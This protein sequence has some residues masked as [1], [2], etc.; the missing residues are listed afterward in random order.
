MTPR[1]TR[2]RFLGGRLTLEQPASGYRAGIDAVLLAA[3]VPAE[4]GERVL[5]LGVGTG[6]ASLCLGARVGGLALSGLEL[7]PAYA[8][9]ARRN[10]A[11]N[12]IPLE[13]VVGDVAEMPAVLRARTF[14]HVMMNPPYH[15]RSEGTPAADPGRETALG[16]AAPL[17]LWV[18]AAAR[19]LR[20]GGH[21]TAIQRAERLPGLLSALDGR[22]GSIAVLPVAPRSGR[23][24]R[25]VILRARKG[26]RGAFRLLAPLILHEGERHLRDGESYR[27]EVQAVLRDGGAIAL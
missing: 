27:D 3:A 23:P 14:D 10:A 1:L 20:P 25:L 22:L 6:A 21:L 9:L 19:R 7:Q 4:P 11:A 2:D 12:G 8:D 13:V 15:L 17:H 16:E 18:E 5:E 26:G 24:A